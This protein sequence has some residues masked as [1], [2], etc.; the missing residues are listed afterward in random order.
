MD[1]IPKVDNFIIHSQILGLS[2]RLRVIIKI[3]DASVLVN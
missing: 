2:P 3:L 1:N